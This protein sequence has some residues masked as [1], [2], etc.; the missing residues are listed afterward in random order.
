MSL[1]RLL[2]NV[3]MVYYIIVGQNKSERKVF[4]ILTAPRLLSAVCS[5]II[6]DT[7]LVATCMLRSVVF[8]YCLYTLDCVLQC[9]C[10]LNYDTYVTI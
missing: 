3:S 2:F 5:S 6:R 10:Y 7:C 1:I 9:R 8:F 4:F